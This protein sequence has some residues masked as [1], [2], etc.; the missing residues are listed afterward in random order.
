MKI[1]VYKIPCFFGRHKWVSFHPTM[2]TM[3]KCSVCGKV[4]KF[5]AAD[6]LSMEQKHN[7]QINKA[8]SATTKLDQDNN[9]T[10]KI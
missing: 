9:L 4:K 6:G 10:E 7:E 8:N 5:S 3:K 1:S 2:M